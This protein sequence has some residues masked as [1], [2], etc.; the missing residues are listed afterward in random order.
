[1]AEA[2]V[3]RNIEP[4]P[5]RTLQK[6][7]E[8]NTSN[9]TESE[10]E[11]TPESTK[12]KSKWIENDDDVYT[13]N[14]PAYLVLYDYAKGKKPCM[15]YT[16][17]TGTTYYVHVLT[18]SPQ[19]TY[20]TSIED[21][22]KRYLPI[23]KS[24]HDLTQYYDS[25]TFP[26][27][28]DGIY[29]WIVGDKGKFLAGRV[30]S[31]LEMGTLH[32]QLADVSKSKHIV[33]AG[34]CS[35]KGNEVYFNIQSGTFSLAIIRRK[36]KS[37]LNEATKQQLLQEKGHAIFES[38]GLTP[39]AFGGTYSLINPRTTPITKE[40]LQQYVQ[41]GFDVYL[42]EKREDCKGDLFTKDYPRAIR[43]QEGGSRQ[44]RRSGRRRPMT[45]RRVG[46]KRPTNQ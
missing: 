5:F 22:R 39:I 11:A 24:I 17:E 41:A 8:Y 1:M 18:S 44:T 43:F 10:P 15:P 13:E 34:E 23:R 36:N 32:K 45:R 4:I 29:T 26:D 12:P 27:A 37:R 42:Y 31:I 3:V 28:P 16:D 19:K 7:P 2:G 21:F 46:R 40:E 30:R 9:E 6:Y 14:D 20:S 25:S 38:M 35:K 33:V